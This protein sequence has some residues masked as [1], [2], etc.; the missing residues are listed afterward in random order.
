M[1]ENDSVNKFVRIQIFESKS[2]ASLLSAPTIDRYNA[3]PPVYLAFPDSSPY[4]IHSYFPQE[5]IYMKTIFQ[6]LEIIFAKTK[7][8]RLQLSSEH[9]VKSLASMAILKGTGR[10]AHSQG[11]WGVY[12]R[13]E[14]D[15]NNN[16][17]MSLTDSSEFQAEADLEKAVLQQGQNL[18]NDNLRK[19]INLR[20]HG[21]I[22]APEEKDSNVQFSSADFVIKSKY[23]GV[24]DF[25]PTIDLRLQGSDVFAGIKDLAMNRIIDILRIPGWL[26]GENGVSSGTVSDGIFGTG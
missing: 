1:V 4:V 24:S 9:P 11:A 22:Q 21:N 17:L 3:A 23:T 18:S 16:P 2:V 15:F 6:A 25:V 5:N 10:S 8:L 14:A 13:G 7:P 20:F 12:A 19:L 26:T